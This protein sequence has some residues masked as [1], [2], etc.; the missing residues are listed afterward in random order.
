M[1][2]KSFF[3]LLR[4]LVLDNRLLYRKKS[5]YH[6]ERGRTCSSAVREVYAK[7]TKVQPLRITPLADIVMRLV[8]RWVERI[9]D[10]SHKN[11][12]R[13]PNSFRVGRTRAYSFLFGCLFSVSKKSHDERRYSPAWHDPLRGK[14][15]VG[16][17]LLVLGA[18]RG[19]AEGFLHAA[20]P[21]PRRAV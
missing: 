14:S 10:F 6:A 20:L 13:K 3:R 1:V 15:P 19:V 11:C 21:L 17:P 18:H 12:A 2:R 7:R 9:F 8:V 5:L 16:S 4:L